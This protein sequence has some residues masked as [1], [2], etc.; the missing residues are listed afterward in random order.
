M[1]Y[2]VLY[3]LESFHLEGKIQT[4]VQLELNLEF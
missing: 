4:L 1:M 2:N 3:I